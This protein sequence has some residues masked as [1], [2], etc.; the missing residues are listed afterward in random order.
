MPRVHAVEVGRGLK[1][2]F[3]ERHK[4]D[5]PRAEDAWQALVALADRLREDPLAG[6]Q[7][8]KRLFPAA[9]REHDNLWKLNLP[10]GFRALYTVL[11]R[12]GG[13]VRVAVEWVGDH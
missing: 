5:T 11:G 4:K 13:G 2:D 9:F 6:E 7:V 1:N 12:P 8:Q 3:F 10:H